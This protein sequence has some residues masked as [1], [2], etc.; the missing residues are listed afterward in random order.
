MKIVSPQRFSGALVVCLLA[1]G[2]AWADEGPAPLLAPLS[3]GS[4]LVLP[5]LDPAVPSPQVVLGYSLGSRF[6]SHDRILAYLARLAEASPRVR[7]WDYGESY[8]HR[9]LKL[10][11]ISSA[12]NIERLE[13]LR[14]RHLRQISAA[15]MSGAEAD[16]QAA[17]LPT[18]VWLGYGIH[19]N[20]SSSAEAA[21]G[22]AYVLAAARG[23]WDRLLRDVIV[24]V[25]PLQNPDGRERYVNTFRQRRGNEADP[26]PNALEH[27]EPWPGGRFNH[28]MIDLNRDWAWATQRETRDRLAAYRQWEPHVVVDLH[29]MGSGST[30]FFPPVAEPKHPRIDARVLRWLSAFGK[31]TA[32]AFDALGWLFFNADR[33]DLLY[34]GYGDSYPSLRGAVGMTYEMAGGG[35]AGEI[36]RLPDGSL[37]SLADR[38]ARHLAS[39]LATVKTAAEN[40]L[41]LRRDFVAN[42]RAASTRPVRTLLW[43]V[44]QPEAR[45]LA[46]LLTLHGI[47]VEQLN[48]DTELDVQSIDDLV[49]KRVRFPRG[50]LAVSLAQPLGALAAALLEVETPLGTDFIAAQR[51]RVAQSLDS[52]FY[53][54]TAWALPLAYNLDHWT[55]DSAV[56]G[57]TAWRP[58][59]GEITGVGEVGYLL[60]PQGL[61]SYRAVAELGRRGIRARLALVPLTLNGVEHPAGTL[62]IPRRGNSENLENQ[63]AA[64]AATERVTLER[65]ASSASE[66]GASMGS[67]DIRPLRPSRIALVGGTGVNATAHGTLWHLLDETLGLQPLRLGVDDLVDRLDDVQV[68]V[69][70][71]GPGYGGAL[72]ANQTAAIERWVR[73]GGVLVALGDAVTWA[74]E[75]RL[76]DVK[77]WKPPLDDGEGHE[78][79]VSLSPMAMRP[80]DTPGAILATAMRAVHPLAAGLPRSPPVMFQGSRVVLPTF[81]PEETVLTV[82]SEEPVLA[83]VAWEEARERL[84]GSLLVAD[85]RLG[86]GRVIL[87]AQ[88]PA[89]R[90]F[91][92]G[93]MPLFLN[94]VMFA[95]SW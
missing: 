95:P 17:N 45:A 36:L 66:V 38:A 88:D 54:I 16:S 30:Y 2:L 91:F 64:I 39:S 11:A 22:L 9:P 58:G 86:K 43:R 27:V 13:D 7:M 10:I 25:D 79:G 51:Q 53:D 56:S 82:A 24:L 48:R 75:A 26:D 93:S 14:R 55:L 62:L 23:D 76:A 90:L 4:E 49:Q 21:L 33:Y 1:I 68:L 80:L 84:A 52:E 15:A 50:S 20:E 63:L 65:V 12:E 44:D 77:L 6:T 59:P 31:N 81:P 94:A 18:L 83:G 69:L 29:E 73:A 70:P 78:E 37:L 57:T 72:G 35:K 3:D 92:R 5:E 87:F 19:G 40:R 61:P 8:E 41:A 71:D 74:G 67:D 60:P 47:A 42:L 89:F 28:Y 32:R 46:E 34:P 85:H